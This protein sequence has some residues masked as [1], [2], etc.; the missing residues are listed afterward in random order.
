MEWIKKFWWI[1]LIVIL[2][3]PIGIN[4]ILL[5]TTPFSIPIVGSETDW[6]S[7]WGGYLGAI[8][9]AAVAFIILYIQRKDDESQNEKN[10]VDNEVQNEKNRSKN[11]KQNKANRQLQLNIMKYQQQS[12]WLD[13][14][15]D[16]S[17]EYCSTLNCNDLILISNIMWENPHDAFNMVKQLFDNIDIAKTKFV[18][19]RK[20]DEKS[21]KLAN[22][23]GEKVAVY[24]RS[25]N[26][27]Q[28]LILFFKSCN[29]MSYRTKTNFIQYIQSHTD[30]KVDI[31][32]I[33]QLAQTQ[34]EYIGNNWIYFNNI[35]LSIYAG[36]DEICPD[37]Q[38]KIY[39][40]IKQEQERI[41]NILTENL[42]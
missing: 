26:D 8:I 34:T 25:L 6:L 23:I 33:L 5:R 39:E 3:L 17:L 15:T 41:D 1:V 29:I 32:H 28:W 40:Y 18:F 35:F 42:E 11:E 14:F 37:I 9:S 19:K 27:I 4:Y 22:Y 16:A 20:L 36:L 31:N 12:H 38:S 30:K 10:R 21:Q 2:V 7:F 13:N 24:K